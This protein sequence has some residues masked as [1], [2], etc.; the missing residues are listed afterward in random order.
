MLLSKTESATDVG[1]VAAGNLG[2]RTPPPP[3]AGDSDSVAAIA[4][5]LRSDCPAIDMPPLEPNAL[6]P[7]APDFPEA[8]DLPLEGVNEKQDQRMR[9]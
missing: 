7:D 1:A 3:A 5:R 4:A 9:K 6:L 8:P 2:A